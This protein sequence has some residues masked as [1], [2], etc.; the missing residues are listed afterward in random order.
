MSTVE[1]AGIFIAYHY[2]EKRWLDRVQASLKPIAECDRAVI[3]DDRKVMSGTAWKTELADALAGAKL[4]ILV[5]SDS[6]LQSGFI[7]R[8]K[9]PAMLD[10]ERENG[11][12]ICW[13]LAGYCLFSVAGLRTDEAGNGINSA[14]DGLNGAGR[15]AALAEFARKVALLLGVPLEA[16]APSAALP[17]FLAPSAPVAPVTPAAPAEPI[18]AKTPAAPVESKVELTPIAPPE[19]SEVK[20][21]QKKR[22]RATPAKAATSE[23]LPL[24][25]VPVTT[26]DAPPELRLPPPPPQPQLQFPGP[27]PQTHLVIPPV[28]TPP[29]AP[30][31]PAAPA[32]APAPFKPLAPTPAPTPAKAP[33]VLRSESPILPALDGVIDARGET[34]V[35]LRKV[36]RW[37][38]LGALG[39]V[40]I[41]IP[42]GLFA[43]LTHFLFVFGFAVFVAALALFLHAHIDVLGQHLVGLRYARSGLADELLPSRQREPLLRKAAEVLG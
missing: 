32:P 23:E 41:S 16:P 8:A 25:L 33:P 13:V 4:A 12:R 43:G 20:P 9:L 24:E 28:E 26:P 34:I 19:T 40:V 10:R 29:A 39:L 14:L 15:D 5:V 31:A 42:V 17:S 27:K 22:K 18:A 6:F 35:L 7:S 36:A 30:A 38:K 1:R 3:W 2:P 21:G 37:L 11:L